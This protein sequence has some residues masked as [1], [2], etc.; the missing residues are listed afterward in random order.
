MIPLGTHVIEGPA[1]QD[2]PVR[3]SV[4]K[5]N[6][7]DV[8]V[9][10]SDYSGVQIVEQ[11]VQELV[12][13]AAETAQVTLAVPP[14]V[15]CVVSPTKYPWKV[16]QPDEKVVSML[17][18]SATASVRTSR[19]RAHAAEEQAGWIRRSDG[20]KALSVRLNE[21]CTHDPQSL[22]SRAC[23]HHFCPVCNGVNNPRL[24]SLKQ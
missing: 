19:A 1:L 13:R 10:D 24:I 21:K 5:C 11:P 16:T 7:E 18:A 9:T 2:I 4:D 12:R 17:R 15:T 8:I 14:G 23:G 3:V 20:V 22:Q 6:P